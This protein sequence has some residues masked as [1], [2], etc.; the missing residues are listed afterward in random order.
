M[1]WHGY[2][3]NLHLGVAKGKQGQLEGHAWV[4]SE[5]KVVIGELPDRCRY[6]PMVSLEG[7]LG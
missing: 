7:F 5:G 6:T 3:A 2:A 1:R 4:E